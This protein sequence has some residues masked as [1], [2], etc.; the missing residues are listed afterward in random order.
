MENYYYFFCASACEQ[1]S[2]R[3]L[4]MDYNSIEEATKLRIQIILNQHEFD[5]VPQYLSRLSLFCSADTPTFDILP[6]KWAFVEDVYA[7]NGD[8]LTEGCW[9]DQIFSRV[10]KSLIYF[11][12]VTFPL[13][14]RFELVFPV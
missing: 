8:C 6:E 1:R 7:E 10:P 11:N 14:I 5:S 13:H 4:F 12:V 2:H 9:I 3:A